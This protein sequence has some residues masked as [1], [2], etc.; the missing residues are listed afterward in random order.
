MNGSVKSVGC[1]RCGDT[2]FHQSRS[3][4]HGSFEVNL[5][6]RGKRMLVT[7]LRRFLFGGILLRKNLLA[8]TMGWI[9][10]GGIDR[11]LARM[12]ADREKGCERGL[13]YSYS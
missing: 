10:F 3:G 5:P 2:A 6:V 9:V 4:L 8:G 12:G 13:T 1:P 11:G 7:I